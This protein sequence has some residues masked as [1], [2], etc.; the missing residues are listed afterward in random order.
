MIICFNCEPEVKDMLDSLV[1]SG[2]YNN[3]S[4]ALSSAVNSLYVLCNDLEKE[5]SIIISNE[6]TAKHSSYS[7]ASSTQQIIPGILH[8]LGAKSRKETEKSTN[9]EKTVVEIPMIFRLKKLDGKTIM[10]IDIPKPDTEMTKDIPIDK[11]IFGQF[12][13]LLPLKASCRALAHFLQDSPEGIPLN[14]GARHIAEEAAMLGEYLTQHDKKENLSRDAKLSIAFPSL[15]AS[16]EKSRL[17]YANQFVANISKKGIVTGLPFEYKF[18][19]CTAEKPSLINLSESGL[20]FALLPNP[21]LDSNQDNPDK[22]FTDDEIEFLINHIIQHL[23][24]ENSAFGIII[25]TIRQGLNTPEK[26]DDILS[27]NIPENRSINASFI[28]TQRSGVISRMAELG[29]VKRVR[30][31]IRVSY[32]LG[33]NSD[34]Y[35]NINSSEE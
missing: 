12:N 21:V 14:E 4:E 31:G 19:S 30:D 34:I 27:R 32:E 8:S 6:N 9:L 3:Y 35:F 18:I 33:V 23:P 10:P 25:N 29:L 17:R 20:K 15:G 26:I 1:R 13:K 24:V 5:G 2:H 11:W 28:A 22:R 16:N 7:R